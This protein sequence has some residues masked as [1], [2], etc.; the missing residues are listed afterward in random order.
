MQSF[1]AGDTHFP[2]ES[3]FENIIF[4][5]MKKKI[6]LNGRLIEYDLQRKKVK[7]INLRVRRDGSVYVS[8][9]YGTPAQRVSDFVAKNA[10]RVR[11]SQEKVKSFLAAA[12]LAEGDTV[13]FLGEPYRLHLD[14]GALSITFSE[15]VATL[16]RPSGDMDTSDAFLRASALAFHPFIAER[17][18]AFEERFPYYAGCAKEICVKP[19]K[20]CWATCNAYKRRLT[21][22]AY[23]AEMPPRVL[24]GVI[25][26]E[27]VHFYISGHG[28]NFY[29]RLDALYP[30]HKEELYE[31]TRLKNEHFMKRKKK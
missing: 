17:C 6:L 21:F 11:A 24:E 28:A 7:N 31:L 2:H 8:A 23:L 1:F 30:R 20:T 4:N 15:G 25:A 22:S 19:M 26:H 3:K 29:K 16:C 27:Y 5:N 18:R 9:P 12:P 10:D 14:F 13:Y